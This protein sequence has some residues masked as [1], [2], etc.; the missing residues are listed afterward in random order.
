[1]MSDDYVESHGAIFQF[2][3]ENNGKKNTKIYKENS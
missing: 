1:M 3:F 2:F